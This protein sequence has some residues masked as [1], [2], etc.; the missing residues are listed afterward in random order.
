MT[1]ANY[2]QCFLNGFLTLIALILLNLAITQG[3]AGP[4]CALSAT[5][6][7]FTTVLDTIFYKQ[8]PN[9]FEISGMIIGLVGAVAISLGPFFAHL[10][11]LLKRKNQNAKFI[12]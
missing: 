4:V 6:N 12:D 11:H 7:I 3:Y 1:T 2:I 9:G 10:I 8:I 5:Q